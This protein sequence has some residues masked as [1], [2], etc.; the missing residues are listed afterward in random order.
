MVIVYGASDDL[1]EVEGDICAEFYAAAD[2]T[3]T[4]LGFSDGTVLKVA[5][6]DE[7]IWRVNR[8]AVGSAEYQKTEATDP[9]GDYTD[10]VQ[11]TGCIHSWVLQGTMLHRAT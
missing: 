5:Y 10:R 7:G 4:L 2:D 11:L 1:I 3:P 6:D 8:V 9:D